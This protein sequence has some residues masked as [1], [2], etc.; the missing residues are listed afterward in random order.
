MRVARA[1][2]PVHESLKVEPH[3]Y[4]QGLSDC[5]ALSIFGFME[6]MGLWKIWVYGKYSNVEAPDHQSGFDLQSKSALT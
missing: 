1:E 4:V 5:S 2:I 3:V 6:N